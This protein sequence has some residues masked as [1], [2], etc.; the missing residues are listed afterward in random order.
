MTHSGIKPDI[1]DV[2]FLDKFFIAACLAGDIRRQQLGGVFF[3]PDIRTMGFKQPV[4]ILHDPVIQQQCFALIA[5][6]NRNRHT[7]GPLPGNTPVRPVF[8][9]AVNSIAPPTGYPL[10]GVDCRQRILAQVIFLH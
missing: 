3:K 4:D 10:D 2:G 6:K 9:H 7:P 8:N 1:Q 5:V